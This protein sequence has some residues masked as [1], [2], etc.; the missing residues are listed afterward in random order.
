VR[1]L[2]YFALLVLPLFAQEPVR[3]EV[4]FPNAAHHE[5][6]VRATF[7]GVRAP[8]LEVVMSRSSPGRYALHEFAKNVYNF[9][10]TDGAGGT[11]EVSR[12]NPYQ[13]NVAGHKGT[14]VVEYTLFGDRSDGTYDGIDVTHAHLNIPA[15]F[16]WAHGFEKR[17]VLVKFDIPP[18]SNWKVATQLIPHDDGTW[19][20]PNLDWFMDS[21]AELGPVTMPEWKV[22][23]VRFRLALHHAGTEEE[24]VAYARMC[25]AVVTEAQGVFGGFPKYDNGMYTFLVDYLPYVNGDGME[26]RDSTVI[27]G[28]SQLK[29]SA[30]WSIGTVSHEFFHSWNVERI[31]PK[32]LEPF[33]F[34]RANMS[35]ELW[36]AEGFTSYY[37]ALILKR[38]GLASLDDLARGLGSAVSAVTTTPGRNVFNAVDMSRQAPFVD[39]AT[40]NEPVNTSNTFISYY[41]YGE[42]LGLGIDLAI[43]SRFPGKSLDDWMRAMWRHHPD[44]QRPYTLNDLEKTLAEATGSKEFAAGIFRRHVYGKEPMEYET[45]LARAGMLL[46]KRGPGKVWL[47][48]NQLNFSANGIDLSGST[49]RDSPLFA[50]GLDRG[51]RVTQWDGR[52]LKSQQELDL[53]LASR[54]PGAVAQLQVEGRAGKRQVDI[55]LSEAPSLQI[56]VYEQAGREVTPEMA[57]FRQAWLGSKAIHPLPKLYRYCPECRRAFPFE[58]SFC[59]YDGKALTI[60]PPSKMAE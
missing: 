37:G 32:T 52:T 30:Q 42:A 34:E 8:E 39:A 15:T 50:A 9:R 35:G 48:V 45:L 4:R 56:V 46:K 24:A 59:P 41:T 22:G 38:A 51:D 40:A 33:D 43:R 21:P 60:T 1:S 29:S 54:K 5:A 55:T 36:F 11:L 23:D 6:E 26:H 44:V 57:A 14:V 16:A 25:E 53:W 58:E 12:P 17:P 18:G 28:T 10:A 20:A 19:S 13:W 49:F 27:T 47:G 31:R 2:F 3:Y 7:A